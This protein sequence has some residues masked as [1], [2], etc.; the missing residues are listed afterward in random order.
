MPNP[1]FVL[2]PELIPTHPERESPTELYP[3][4]DRGNDP[5]PCRAR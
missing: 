1:L 2:T 3:S 4:L 5:V